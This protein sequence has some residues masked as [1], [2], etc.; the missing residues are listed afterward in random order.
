MK[1]I[2]CFAVAVFT[3]ASLNAQDNIS[4]VVSEIDVNNT[5]LKAL[6]ADMKAQ[7]IGNRTGIFL[8]N[9]EVEFGYLWGSPGSIGT[10]KDLGLTQTFDFA[11]VSGMKRR[12][13]K[14]RDRLAE[15]QY[16]AD[17]QAILLEARNY[18]VELVYYNAV[19]RELDRRIS[20]AAELETAW[21]RRL[22]N[23]DAGILEY[24]KA[25][26]SLVSL[27]GE[28]SRME[29]ER[30][31]LLAGLRRLNGGID[32]AFDDSSYNSLPMPSDFNSW[33][34]SAEAKSPA[35]KYVRQQTE[36]SR[37][38]MKLS[39]AEGLPNISAGYTSERTMEET[40]QGISVGISI[41]LWENK[42]KI[43]QAKAAVSA[44]EARQ[45]DAV[46]QFYV[47]LQ[48]LYDRAAGLKSVMDGYRE[49]LASARNNNELLVKALDA[50]Q[51]SIVDYIVESSMYYDTVEQAL[52]AERDYELA[53]AELY[54]N[55]GE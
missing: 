2:I 39:R 37:G 54:S 55:T 43:R 20:R 47:R 34:A 42:N 30:K 15:Y 25:K 51:I 44:A 33:Y 46:E 16:M 11:T 3:C 9:P 4:A 17:R 22:D 50:G 14:S 35:L 41:P 45:A 21:K 6:R 12:M 5:T 18:C 40:F 23:G 7:Q 31:A 27:K 52:A 36:V 48:E 28:K 49:T 19:C 10:K 8:P 26:L 38:E 53:K 13:A 32:I 1:T 29:V 24:N